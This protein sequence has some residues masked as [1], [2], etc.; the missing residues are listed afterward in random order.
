MGAVKGTPESVLAKQAAR[1]VREKL[2][3]LVRT[4][5]WF[6]D[7]NI[8]LIAGI[9]AFKVHRGQLQR[10]SEVFHDLFS[11]P[12]PADQQLVDGCLWVEL[13]DEPS[14]VYYFLMALYDG[15]YVSCTSYSPFFS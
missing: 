11:I 10:H 13:H 7:G 5:F 1:A 2:A 3:T 12:Q 15:L 9:A 14:D 8:V 4:D 6:A